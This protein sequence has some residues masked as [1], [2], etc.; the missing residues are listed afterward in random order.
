VGRRRAYRNLEREALAARFPVHVTVRL[1]TGLPNL[2]RRKEYAALR[3]AFGKG[4]ARFG[5]RLVHYSVQGNHLHLLVE[6]QGRSALARG[7]QGLLVRIARGL[8]RL[9]ARRGSVFADR[10]HDRILRT[11]H[12]VRRA[13][14]YVL[15]NAKRHGLLIR[16]GVDHFS[17]GYWFDGWREA[18]TVRGLAAITR[19]VAA[20]RTWLLGV[21]WRRHRLLRFDEAPQP[22]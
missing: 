9:W 22:A 20:A 6:A 5:F 11:P 8:N 15:H 2:R 18:P 7:M 14:V 1:R 19:P 10:Y 13:L 17:S 12:E 4:C 3:A 21:G 16:D